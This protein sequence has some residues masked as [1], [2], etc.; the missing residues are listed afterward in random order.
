MC[1]GDEGDTVGRMKGVW[2]EE[3]R[4]RDEGVVSDGGGGNRKRRE[5]AGVAWVGCV[6][7]SVVGFVAAD[8]ECRCE[9]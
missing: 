4:V 1:V 6:V 8:V 3:E 2:R 9:R 5:G 7:G